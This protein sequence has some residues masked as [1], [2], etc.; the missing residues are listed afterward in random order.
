[1]RI[2]LYTGK[3]G[4]G[5]STI[6]AAT[7][8]RCAV[9]GYRTLLMS[10]D[11]SAGPADALDAPV[12]CDPTPLAGRLAAQRIDAEREISRRWAAVSEPA[13]TM[14]GDLASLSG[15]AELM[16]LAALAEQAES[17]SHD[18]IVLDGP[19][20]AALTRLLNL[21]EAARRWSGREP[22]LGSLVEH[23]SRS[24]AGRL[25]AG[26]ALLRR[27]RGSALDTLAHADTAAALLAGA[28]TGSVRVVL[29]PQRGALREGR[30]L[31]TALHL[32]GYPVD[33]V[34]CNRLAPAV[35]TYSVAGERSD[36]RGERLRALAEAFAP[37][38]L[39]DVPVLGDE[40]VG[41]DALHELARAAFGER[42]PTDV[43]YRGPSA[44]FV[45]DGAEAVLTLPA[46]LASGADLSV[47]QTGDDITV[48]GA[49]VRRVITLPPDLSGRACR[50]AG[51]D[52]QALRLQFGSHHHG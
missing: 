9:L 35:S 47:T 48:R 45:V 4:T 32:L 10:L 29:T 28:G 19:S 17:G 38:P 34:V 49:G 36:A 40:I 37:V 51:F 3:G 26:P 16:G 39:L 1:M 2:I 11:G 18:V 42:D 52:G 43:F 41:M 50:A 8:L 46:P 22:S 30:R 23:L 12:G 44:A 21:A 27:L 14:P 25:A 24:L 6:A 5:V 15:M 13:D 33:A 31:F 7:A 20:A